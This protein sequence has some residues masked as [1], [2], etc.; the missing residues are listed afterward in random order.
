MMETILE[1]EAEEAGLTPAEPRIPPLFYVESTEQPGVYVRSFKLPENIFPPY[2]EPIPLW[3]KSMFAVDAAPLL[4]VTG[5]DNIPPLFFYSASQPLPSEFVMRFNDRPKSFYLSLTHDNSLVNI[6]D[7]SPRLRCGPAAQRVFRTPELMENIFLNL[8]AATV[9]TSIKRVSKTFK[10]VVDGSLALQRKLHFKPHPNAQ[11]GLHPQAKWNK[12]DRTEFP[13]LNPLL[14][15]H[16]GGCFFTFGGAYGCLRRAESFYENKWTPH[17]HML[18]KV[19]MIGRKRV[20][21][22][23][24]PDLDDREITQSIQDRERFT[25]ASASWRK[26][27]VCQP[28]IYD[29]GAMI[30]EPSSPPFSLPQQMERAIIQA[31]DEDHGLCMGQLYDFVQERA[32]YHPLD[33]VRFRLTWFDSQAPFVSE[34]C[35]NTTRQW[36]IDGVAIV[37]EMFRTEVNF[38]AYQPDSPERDLFEDNF[39]C[40]DFKR[41]QWIPDDTVMDYHEPA[42]N[43]TSPPVAGM[44]M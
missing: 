3:M 30:S 14:V 41:H 9:L 7:T 38:L 29:F 1:D 39:K 40:K 20:Y 15:K 23:V 18:K 13:I 19:N 26:M 16:F 36:I 11:T 34:L 6:H 2:L 31:E 24:C 33:S 25:R 44:Q 37:I 4:H 42:Y 22:S 10:D 32:G 8:D 21:T 28:P 35:R 5:F 27:L 43:P 17:H 12:D